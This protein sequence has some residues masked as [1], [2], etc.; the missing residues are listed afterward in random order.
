MNYTFS[1]GTNKR[2]N[3]PA[4]YQVETFSEFRD[5]VLADRSADK[6]LAFI[7][8]PLDVEG[9]LTE[10][11]GYRNLH[12]PQPRQWLPLDI[13]GCIDAEASHDLIAFLHRYRGFAYTT[14]SH[15][16]ANPR[17]RIVLD[18]TRAVDRGEGES[19]GVAFEQ[20]LV[21]ALGPGRFKFDESVYRGEQPCYTPL[22]EAQSY[23]FDGDPLDVERLLSNYRPPAAGAGQGTTAKTPGRYP[24]WLAK[25]VAGQ[26]LHPPACAVVASM[27][28]KKMDAPTI[29]MVFEVLRPKLEEVRGNKRIRDFFEGGELEDLI[30]SA[31]A[32]IK[33]N[34]VIEKDFD[35]FVLSQSADQMEAEMDADTYVMARLAIKGQ[36]TVVYG[37]HNHGKTLLTLRGVCRQIE[38]GEIDASQVYYVNADDHGRGIAQKQRLA[39]KYG[40]KMLVPGRNGFQADMLRPLLKARVDNDRAGESI[41]ILDTLKKFTDLMSKRE[42]TAWGNASREF[43][44]A[45]GSMIS[46]AHTNKHKDD[47]GQSVYAGTADIVQDCDCAYILELVSEDAGAR[48]VEFRNIK[49]R[50]DVDRKRGFTYTLDVPYQEMFDSVQVIEDREIERA[51]DR[52]HQADALARHHEAIMHIQ[53]LIRSGVTKRKALIEGGYKHPHFSRSYI[54]EVLDAHTGNDLLQGHRWQYSI[55]N[56]NSRIYQLLGVGSQIGTT[57]STE[58]VYTPKTEGVEP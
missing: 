29:R 44:S 6:G 51:R 30:T 56:R 7:C 17:Y 14:A 45:G 50:G 40:F 34:P 2:D 55:G 57:G 53:G 42:G 48:T 58:L 12:N 21:D 35:D 18:L 27:V 3:R 5:L 31:R 28:S 33:N 13:D 10:K 46:L 1:R 54:T 39:E 52:R 9:P 8:A 49:A 25:L 41:V 38:A 47:D 32:L 20:V 43:V 19:L 16:P 11:N 36:C 37:S 26:E 15:T 24:D 23:L 4:Q 22:I